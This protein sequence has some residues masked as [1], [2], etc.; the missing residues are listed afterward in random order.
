MKSRVIRFVGGFIQHRTF[1]DLLRQIKTDVPKLLGY[2]HA[3]VF[4][5][6]NQQ[7]GRENLYCM[8]VP[9]EDATYDRVEDKPGFEQDFIIDEKQVV[10]FPTNMGISGYA[11][12][13]DAVCYINNF[14]SK[15]DATYGE[16]Y[17]Q[18]STS[19]HQVL[20]MPQQA[21]IGHLL[22]KK[23]P[24]NRKIDNFVE[25]ETIENLVICSI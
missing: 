22:A 18:T 11:L 21:F 15:K 16:I 4:M 12:Q 25:L 24:Y 20:T 3:E 10:R 1:K 23:Y 6:D 19:R 17:A 7:V 13:G 2:G 9:M 14:S 8:S 5:Y